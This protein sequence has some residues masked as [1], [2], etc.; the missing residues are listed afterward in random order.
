MCNIH[1]LNPHVPRVSN[2]IRIGTGSYTTPVVPLRP[3]T[4]M[5]ILVL[6]D[7]FFR[8]H[9]FRTSHFCS[10][11]SGVFLQTFLQL[12]RKVQGLKRWLGG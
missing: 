9:V 6:I 10:I 12:K 2:R 3:E 7:F 5:A 4:K 1:S 11:E 8:A